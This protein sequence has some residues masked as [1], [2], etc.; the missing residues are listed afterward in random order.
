MYHL[1]PVIDASV[2]M[3]EHEPNH[4]NVKCEI[5]YFLETITHI[6]SCVIYQG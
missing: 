3:S 4:I 6:R 1:G 5:I 2:S